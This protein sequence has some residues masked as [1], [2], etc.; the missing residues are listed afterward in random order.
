MAL[1]GNATSPTPQSAIISHRHIIWDHR[2]ESG[3]AT[4]V[5]VLFQLPQGVMFPLTLLFAQLDKLN[6]LNPSSPPSTPPHRPCSQR[7]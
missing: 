6:P 5:A 2:E 1:P 7:P 4:S 3:T